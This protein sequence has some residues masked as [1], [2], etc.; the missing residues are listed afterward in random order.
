MLN[1][2]YYG[3]WRPGTGWI[4]RL[5]DWTDFGSGAAS[6]SRTATLAGR[7]R[8]RRADVDNLNTYYADSLLGEAMAAAACR[9]DVR[10]DPEESGLKRD[11]AERR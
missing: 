9:P 2:F 10:A 1:A 8:R 5:I 6:S 4:D 7:N 3:Y 11:T